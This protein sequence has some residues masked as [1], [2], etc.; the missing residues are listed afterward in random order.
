MRHKLIRH[1]INRFT[2]WRKA[3]LHSLVRSILIYQSIKTTK[4]RALLA[5]PEVDRLI[6]LAQED[7]LANKREAFRVLCDH[8]LVSLLFNDIAKRSAGRIGGHTRILN[9]GARRG[10]NAEMVLFELVE[11]K[12]K[13]TKRPKK[14]KEEPEVSE[15]GRPEASKD[16]PAAEEKTE[17]KKPEAKVAVKERPPQT[18]KPTKNFLGGLR[19]IFKKERDSL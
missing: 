12:K 11:I 10:D 2:S 4:Q 1:R 7:S 3:T 5:K 19:N 6:S 14:K 15:K 8:K 9:L 16:A 18:K 17:Q 13:A